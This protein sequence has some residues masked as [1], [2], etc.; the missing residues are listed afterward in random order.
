MYISLDEACSH[1]KAKHFRLIMGVYDE[2]GGQLL[3]TACSQLIRVL[4]NNDCPKGA[5]S[6]EFV[7]TTR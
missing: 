5:A 1:V 4:A 2:A 3:G 7:I 6:I